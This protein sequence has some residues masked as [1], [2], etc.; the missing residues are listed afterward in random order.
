M[1]L[2]AALVILGA[3]IGATFADID[4]A[5]PLPIKH[6]SAWTHGPLIPY[7]VPYLVGLYPIL[8]Y[9]SVGFLPAYSIHLF[10]DMF[11]KSWTGGAHINLFPIP[12][13]LPAPLSFLFLAAGVYASAF[14][15]TNLI[16]EAIWSYLAYFS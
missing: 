12:F 10:L 15:L 14:V 1:I 6:R 2:N 5:P 13:S 9:F 16:G 3:I 7:L 8:F 11:P 4:L